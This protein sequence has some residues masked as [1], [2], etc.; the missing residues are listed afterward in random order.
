MAMTTI[1]P[2]LEF[3]I[4]QVSRARGA[5]VK[6]KGYRAKARCRIPA[7]CDAGFF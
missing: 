5:K 4:N 3:G 7:I 2:S 6:S 1:P